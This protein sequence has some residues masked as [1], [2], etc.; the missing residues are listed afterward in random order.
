MLKIHMSKIFDKKIYLPR[1][2]IPR[3]SAWRKIHSV[4]FIQSS[5]IEKSLLGDKHFFP[6]LVYTCQVGG[7][8]ASQSVFDRTLVSWLENLHCLYTSWEIELTSHCG[9]WGGQGMWFR[10]GQTDTSFS[11]DFGI[12]SERHKGWQKVIH[13]MCDQIFLA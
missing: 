7:N 4:F 6:H 8:S 5:V 3:A 9:N 12:L 1:L 2:R 13:C 10:P 11:Q